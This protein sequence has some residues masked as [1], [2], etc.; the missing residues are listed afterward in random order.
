MI[1]II[2][3]AVYC[4][5]YMLAL[6]AVGIVLQICMDLKEGWSEDEGEPDQEA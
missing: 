1:A 2:S 4:A 6:G 3:W 5:L